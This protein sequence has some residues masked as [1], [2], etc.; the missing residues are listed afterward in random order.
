MASSNA[1]VL[2][3]F[4]IC[5]SFM[6]SEEY[7]LQRFFINQTRV[8]YPQKGA[9]K[10]LQ[11]LGE[12]RLKIKYHIPYLILLIFYFNKEKNVCPSLFYNT[13]FDTANMSI[14]PYLFARKKKYS[15][16]LQSQKKNHLTDVSQTENLKY[17]ITR[18]KSFFFIHQDGSASYLDVK[19]TL[20]FHL[21]SSRMD[22][23]SR[24]LRFFSFLLYLQG[25]LLQW[26][27]QNYLKSRINHSYNQDYVFKSILLFT[28]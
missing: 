28:M 26:C 27:C 6:I 24:S 22:Q 25:T 23:L 2:R 11:R 3:R 1:V 15:I 14:L 10:R 16:N 5:L 13:T 17:Q 4:I 21:L 12:H 8:D 7:L 18:S 9:C 19:L 20:Q